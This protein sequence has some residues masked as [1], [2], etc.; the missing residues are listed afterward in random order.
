MVHDQRA[1][2]TA[3]EEC[4]NRKSG[5]YPP[6]DGLGQNSVE[7]LRRPLR[8]CVRRRQ[9][10]VQLA[11]LAGHHMTRRYEQNVAALSRLKKRL[12]FRAK[13]KA[14]ARL[15]KIERLDAE[16]IAGRDE[17]SGRSI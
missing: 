16:R 2:D 17:F 10:V 4:R 7:L 11:R 8:E 1:V 6:A 15:D 14:S 9:F 3:A 5:R 13:Q 12:D